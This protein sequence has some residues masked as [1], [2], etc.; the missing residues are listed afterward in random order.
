VALK[1]QGQYRDKTGDYWKIIATHANSL[2]SQTIVRVALYVSK[3]ER[4]KDEANYLFV[5]PIILPGVD[6]DREKAYAEVKKNV[7]FEGSE[8]C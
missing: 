2:Y 6:Y 7:Q 5:V 8:D 4:D 3:E 1:K